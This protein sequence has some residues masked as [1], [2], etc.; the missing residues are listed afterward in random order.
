MAY[1]VPPYLKREGEALV[2][3]K[4]K[5]QFIFYVPEQYFTTNNA[6]IIGEFVSLFGLIDYMIVDDNGKS[7]SG[8]K[9]FTFPSVFLSK[10]SSIEKIK[11]YKITK[12]AKPKDYRL[13]KFNKGDQ[14]VVSV[15]VPQDISTVESFYN[16]FNRGNLPPSIPYDK[17]VNIYLDNMRLSDNKYN[18]T[19]QLFG[20]LYSEIYRAH[21]DLDKPFRLSGSKD[22]LA[23]QAIAITE[24]PKKVS[25]YVSLTSEN[26]D[27]SV[28]GAI[29]LGEK[30]KDS[31]LEGILTGDI[32]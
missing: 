29:Q 15:N 14:I 23:Y 25:P 2:F 31:P 32:E 27:N 10:P 22:M 3:N 19:A 30:G 18:I 17:L 24:A 26:W 4:D 8:L 11:E 20:I 6:M 21:D 12:Y 5:Q 1:N 9:P 16:L 13:L 28:I 7:I